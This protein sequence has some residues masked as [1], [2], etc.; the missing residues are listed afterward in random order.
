MR[1]CPET[2]Y[3][4]RF[5]S[6]K[7]CNI[8]LALGSEQ[9]RKPQNKNR[10]GGSL[11]QIL[12]PHSCRKSGVQQ[13]PGPWLNQLGALSE[14]AVALDGRAGTW[15]P[16]WEK[17][18]CVPL[19]RWQDMAKVCSWCGNSGQGW[20]H[21]TF[22]LVRLK[23]TDNEFLPGGSWISVQPPF[24]FPFDEL[25]GPSSSNLPLQV[26]FHRLVY[27]LVPLS[28]IVSSF[29]ASCLLCGC[30]T[31]AQWVGSSF[32][33]RGIPRHYHP[34]L[35]GF[36]LLM[37]TKIRSVHGRLITH[38]DLQPFFGHSFPM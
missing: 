12:W 28:W 15:T 21:G 35:P 31:R 33:N 1:A 14:C 20:W 11:P 32:R 4:T 8:S 5:T 17:G 9:R 26:I 18:Q 38:H 16:L 36:P 24:S 22:L 10:A 2:G 34:L 25:N 7:Q 30:E 19:L 13:A 37:H 6:L 23:T 27:I 29:S 3:A